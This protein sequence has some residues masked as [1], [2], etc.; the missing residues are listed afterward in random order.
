MAAP[1]ANAAPNKTGGPLIG[2]GAVASGRGG[3]AVG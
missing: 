2:K 1:A 3:G